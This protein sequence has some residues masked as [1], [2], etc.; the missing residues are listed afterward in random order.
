MMGHCCS[1]RRGVQ[2]GIGWWDTL[3][4]RV[5]SVLFTHSA[6]AQETQKGHKPLTLQ[7]LFLG[8]K[9]GW[10][11]SKY[12]GNKQRIRR[13]LSE[14]QQRARDGWMDKCKEGCI[15]PDSLFK[16][17]PKSISAVYWSVFLSNRPK[18]SPDKQFYVISTLFNCCSFSDSVSLSS[19]V[20]LDLLKKQC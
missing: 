8:L 20:F 19:F 13:Y 1:N 2:E 15:L 6:D 16:F 12:K 7:C 4:C 9:W 17:P 10:C 18:L 3:K 11:Y 14:S 5:F